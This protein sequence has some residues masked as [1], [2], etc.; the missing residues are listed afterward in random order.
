MT[1]QPSVPDATDISNET[2]PD[3][4]IVI[5]LFVENSETTN[6]PTD[7][8]PITSTP[9]T[10]EKNKKERKNEE[11]FVNLHS[12]DT[13]KNADTITRTIEHGAEILFKSDRHT[14]PVIFEFYPAKRMN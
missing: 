3:I 4:T 14:T 11:I 5:S 13:I 2:T 6:D 10:A 12:T 8:I 7:S 9:T 1:S